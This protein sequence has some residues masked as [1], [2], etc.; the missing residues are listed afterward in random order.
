MLTL[1]LIQENMKLNLLM[2]LF[3]NMLQTIFPKNMY[4]QVNDKGNMFQ[5]LD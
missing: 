5:S 4:A 2:G 1:S 3:N